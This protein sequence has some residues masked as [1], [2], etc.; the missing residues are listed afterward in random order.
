MYR[1][2]PFS[3]SAAASVLFT[4]TPFADPR[5]RA[6]GSSSPSSSTCGGAIAARAP[7]TD[8]AHG[9]NIESAQVGAFFH[10]ARGHTSVS[11][12]AHMPLPLCLLMSHS[13]RGFFRSRA[14]PPTSW[15]PSS[16]PPRVSLPRACPILRPRA[17][18]PRTQGLATLRSPRASE[19]HSAR[20][21]PPPRGTLLAVAVCVEILQAPFELSAA[22]GPISP[23]CRIHTPPKLF[24]FSL[25]FAG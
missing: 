19:P 24:S 22:C 8:F 17:G 10:G 13:R 16:P 5:R 25:L 4:F 3:N 20:D 1:Y 11:Q 2:T 21:S 12:G 14:P 23:C 6:L 7:R 15:P 9:L 18:L